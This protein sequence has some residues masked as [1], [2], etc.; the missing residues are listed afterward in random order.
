MP[1]PATLRVA[2][3]VGLAWLVFGPATTAVEDL[4]GREPMRVK[5]FLEKRRSTLRQSM[6]PSD[7]T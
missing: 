7:V 1:E 4:T 6:S 5:A 2:F 3:D